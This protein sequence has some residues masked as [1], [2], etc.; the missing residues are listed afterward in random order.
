MGHNFHFCNFPAGYCCLPLLGL[1]LHQGICIT[2]VDVVLAATIPSSAL[3]ICF[4]R[5]AATGCSLLSATIW[6]K[7]ERGLDEVLKSDEAFLG[8]KVALEY[9]ISQDDEKLLLY[10][11]WCQKKFTSVFCNHVLMSPPQLSQIK[12]SQGQMPRWMASPLS[13]GKIECEA[14][15]EVFFWVAY[16]FPN[17]ERICYTSTYLWPLL[18]DKL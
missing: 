3:I 16:F 9:Q 7:H 18:T 13:N 4:K 6:E 5:Q 15:G 11:S 1:N 10:S 8:N 14:H 12:V 2:N 17:C